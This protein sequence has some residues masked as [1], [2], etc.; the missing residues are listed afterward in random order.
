MI[1]FGLVII[2]ALF[3]VGCSE[4]NNFGPYGSTH[5]HI[6]YKVYILGKPINFDLPRYQVMEDLTHVEN[7][8]GGVIHV[9]ATG[10]TLGYF[11]RSLG[12]GLTDECFVLDTGNQ[13]C[14]DGNAELKVFVQSIGTSWVQIYSP[15]DYIIQDL[16]KIL[17][18]FGTEDE[19][20][21]RQQLESV[22]DK[23][24]TY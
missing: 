14:S 21:I 15:A 20:G 11:F 16:D 4:K 13:Y 3:L 10:M 5:I 12:F 2:S 17:I 7:N 18:T 24:R 22:T 6:D 8:D 23:A 9:H 1:I 19:E